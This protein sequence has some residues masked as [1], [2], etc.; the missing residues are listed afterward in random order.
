[1]NWNGCWESDGEGTGEGEHCE[2]SM[3]SG[4]VMRY[5]TYELVDT[6]ILGCGLEEQSGWASVGY[7][8]CS[9]LLSG[10]L[11]LSRSDRSPSFS[12]R[13][14]LETW[15]SPFESTLEARRVF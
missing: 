8:S 14:M 7:P 10:L 3:G 5:E 6:R 1:M 15:N 13:P 4:Q 2:A 9:V 11:R 12:T